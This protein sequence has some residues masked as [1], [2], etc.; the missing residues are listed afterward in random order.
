MAEGEALMD[1][2][3]NM[4]EHEVHSLRRDVKQLQD[5]LLLTKAII[6]QNV[7][8]LQDIMEQVNK[9]RELADG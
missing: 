7:Q 4:L 5:D 9:E 3:A 8:L 1:I 2:R 6:E